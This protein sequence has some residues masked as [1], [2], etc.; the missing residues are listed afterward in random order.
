LGITHTTSLANVQ[1]NASWGNTQYTMYNRYCE[2]GE[3]GFIKIFVHIAKHEP[4][5]LNMKAFMY[6]QT[7]STNTEVISVLSSSLSV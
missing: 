3:T 7:T 5:P 6:S 1:G 2:A 4:P